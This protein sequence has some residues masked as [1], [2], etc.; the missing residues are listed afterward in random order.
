MVIINE[1]YKVL[2]FLYKFVSVL[3]D[4]FGTLEEESIRDNFVIIYELLD[5][6]F[7]LFNGV[8][9]SSDEVLGAIGNG[10]DFEK[11]ILIY[12]TSNFCQYWS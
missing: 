8:F 4:Y 7:K 3:K 12:H 6:K 5:E 9:G 11:R 10:I 1:F 2:T